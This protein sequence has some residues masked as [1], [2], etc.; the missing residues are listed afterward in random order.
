MI[1]TAVVLV[2]ALG[3]SLLALGSCG[4]ASHTVP[5]TLPDEVAI[6]LDGERMRVRWSD[7]DSF[8]FLDGPH[9]GAGV[10]LGRYNTLESYGPAHRWGDWTADELYKLAKSS[11]YLAAQQVW[12]CT[13]AGDKD[14]Y[15]RLL[16]DCPDVATAMVEAGHAHIF[17]LEGEPPEQLLKAQRKARKKKRGMWA[18]GTPDMI[19]TSLHSADEKE[20]GNAYNRHVDAH[21]GISTV[22]EHSEVYATCQEVCDGGETGSCMIYVPFKIRY[23]NKPDCLK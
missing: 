22:R 18:K 3:T 7:G 6:T 4:T 15:G 10:R 9:K 5:T 21:T 23:R 17:Y 14:G 16:V 20:D 2:L 1:R 12:S 8:K 19:V 13:T 11:R